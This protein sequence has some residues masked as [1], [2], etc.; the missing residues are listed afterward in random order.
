MTVI[1]DRNMPAPWGD[2]VSCG[3]PASAGLPL[4]I[5]E[6]DPHC[7]AC[8]RDALLSKAAIDNLEE[9]AGPII[10][11]WANHWASVGVSQ[12]EIVG[13]LSHFSGAELHYTARAKYIRS[14]LAHLRRENRAPVFEHHPADRVEL[15]AADLPRLA[16][17]T[18]PA[19]AGRGYSAH[20]G[21]FT[22]TQGKARTLSPGCD[23]LFISQPDGDTLLI[24]TGVRGFTDPTRREGFQVPADLLPQVR[25]ALAGEA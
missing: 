17:Y 7:P 14:H 25:A 22:D 24:Y 21:F 1:T 23:M 18:P 11:A 9:L 4:S 15:A 2:C 19:P 6:G 13:A 16:R 20:G 3:R 5:R 10:G 12:N 8:T